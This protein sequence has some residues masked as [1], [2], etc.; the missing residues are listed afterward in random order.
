MVIWQS[1]KDNSRCVIL[2]ARVHAD[3]R[4]VVF[5]RAFRFLHGFALISILL[6]T[7]FVVVVFFLCW[8]LSYILC[9]FV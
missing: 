8:V 6:Y 5:G 7:P 1:P 3:M 2:K 9:V 4:L